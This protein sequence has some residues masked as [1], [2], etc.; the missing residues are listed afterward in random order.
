MLQG[1]LS[2]SLISFLIVAQRNIWLEIGILRRCQFAGVV[3]IQFNLSPDCIVDA[4]DE[5]RVTGKI[6]QTVT[7]LD[8]LGT[9]RNNWLPSNWIVHH[10]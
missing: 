4:V 10:Y 5:I 9:K 1:E 7:K 3:F 2:V 6:Y 8:I